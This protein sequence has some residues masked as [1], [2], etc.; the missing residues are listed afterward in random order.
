MLWWLILC[1][2]ESWSWDAQILGK[3]NSGCVYKC[4]SEWDLTFE[5]LDWIKESAL[6]RVG[7]PHPIHWRLQ[8][9]KNDGIKENPLSLLAFELI[10]ESS[11]AFSL[12]LV[13]EFT[14]S[15]LLLLRPSGSV[16]NYVWLSRVFS[17]FTADLGTPEPL[18]LHEPITY[19][20]SNSLSP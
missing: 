10:Y 6:P 16:W 12:R 9:N 13:L 4:I 15:A 18:Q 7:G 20:K 14:S 3:H 5:L 17:F 2:N 19:N 1:A 11:P 8:K